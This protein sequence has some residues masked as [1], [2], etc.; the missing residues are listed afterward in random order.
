MCICVESSSMQ[1]LLKYS[2]SWVY[3]QSINHQ[4]SHII[5]GHKANSF[6]SPGHHPQGRG[7][8]QVTLG[9]GE[10]ESWSGRDQLPWVALASAFPR[11]LLPRH[12]S[13][14]PGRHSAAV[15]L[16]ELFLFVILPGIAASQWLPY[17]FIW[18]LRK[19]IRYEFFV[20]FVTMASDKT[21]S[22]PWT[23]RP[24]CPCSLPSGVTI[25]FLLSVSGIQ[26][27]TA[28]AWQLGSLRVLSTDIEP[29]PFL[30]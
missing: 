29:L 13:F 6:S 30:L 22:A 5:W 20:G 14:S 16:V 21:G 10:A 12:P 2:K 7:R 28:D 15:V 9:T 17:L 4:P 19:T 27:L 8:G 25:S 18:A 1:E 11:L 3:L 23:P 26:W 24:R